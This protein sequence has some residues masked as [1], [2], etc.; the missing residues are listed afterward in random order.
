M[1]LC[2][3]SS[4]G[5]SGYK[6]KCFVICK[7]KWICQFVSISVN[8]FH[9]GSCH[10]CIVNVHIPPNTPTRQYRNCG[11]YIA[12]RVHILLVLHPS[13]VLY[14]ITDF[15]TDSNPDEHNHFYLWKKKSSH[16]FHVECC[17]ISSNLCALADLRIKQ[18]VST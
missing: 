7:I 18:L 8:K 17:I 4:F 13:P 15:A 6:E 5:T 1:T 11:H 2:L 9:R 3:T 14:N 10:D 12:F 16:F